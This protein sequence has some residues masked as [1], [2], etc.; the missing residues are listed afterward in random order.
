M[1]ILPDLAIRTA[2][3]AALTGLTHGGK[4][5]GVFDGLAPTNYVG[6]RIIIQNQANTPSG[7]KRNYSYRHEVNLSIIDQSATPTGRKRT[8]E[9]TDMVLMKFMPMK[10]GL[11]VLGL[12]GPFALWDIQLAGSHR[13]DLIQSEQCMYRQVLTIHFLIDTI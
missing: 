1:M 11:P 9:I 10:P 13:L 7:D 6:P 8:E 5:I 12:P 2:I 4:A 3:V